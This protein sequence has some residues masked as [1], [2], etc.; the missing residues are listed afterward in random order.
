LDE[1]AASDLIDEIEA[2]HHKT[3]ND[4]FEPILDLGYRGKE[5]RPR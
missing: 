5:P 4:F 1:S 3:S 2:S